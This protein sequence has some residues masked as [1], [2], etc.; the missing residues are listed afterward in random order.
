MK[1]H[2]NVGALAGHLSMTAAIVG[3]VAIA[4]LIDVQWSLSRIDPNDSATWPNMTPEVRYRFIPV[5]AALLSLGAALIN[6][7]LQLLD[8][9]RLQHARH[10]VLLGVAFGSVLLGFPLTRIGFNPS[11]AFA[12]SLAIALAAFLGVRSRYGVPVDQAAV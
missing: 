6:F 5:L 3:V 10:W 4:T 1:P 7:F 11:A 9:R 12:I 2:T 8:R